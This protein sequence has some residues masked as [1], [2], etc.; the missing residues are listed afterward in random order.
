M[1]LLPS[2]IIKHLRLYLPRFTDAFSVPIDVASAEVTAARTVKVTTNAAHTLQIGNT[3]VVT[4]GRLEND[5]TGVEYRESDTIVRFTTGAEHDFTKPVKENDP[6]TVQLANFTDSIWNTTH[7]LT[8]I[9]DRTHFEIAVPN[10][11]PIPTL[12]GNEIVYEDRPK[13]LKGTWGITSVPSTTEF[14]FDVSADTPE[15][16]V[17]PIDSLAGTQA[18]EIFSAA[19]MERA[20]AVYTDSSNVVGSTEMTLFIIM[21][22]VD[23]SKDRHTN[24][25][26]VAG[27]YNGDEAR[28][29]TIHNFRTFVFIDTKNDLTGR[30]AQ[31]RAYGEIW[32][33]LLKSL[34]AYRKDNEKSQFL[35]VPIGHG[36]GQYNTA[37]Y[38][39]VYD[40]QLPQDIDQTFGFKDSQDVAFRDINRYNIPP[41][42]PDNPATWRLQIN[43][44]EEQ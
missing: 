3:I 28:L 21:G 20:Q 14:T 7:T 15:L 19:T 11:E 36:I 16:I 17:N 24:T 26:A 6:N 13:S 2:D 8:G 39:H 29:Q 37:Y 1:S 12:N 40:W 32:E 25:D 27:F 35:T 18:S 5:I 10:S 9:P 4:A 31:E 33:A 42:E 43:L 38:M 22:D 34:F 44:D 23:V 30:Q 41:F